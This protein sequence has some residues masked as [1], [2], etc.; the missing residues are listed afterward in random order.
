MSG[1]TAGAARVEDW[2]ARKGTWLREF[3]RE[4]HRAA[5]AGVGGVMLFG[6]P[7]H[8]DAN[9]SGADDAA[10]ILSTG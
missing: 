2:L 5:T 8:K 6:I 9:G 7:E 3:R 4:L 1:S 10:G